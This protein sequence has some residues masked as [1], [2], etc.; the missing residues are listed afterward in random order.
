[1]HLTTASSTAPPSVW[2]EPHS[3]LDGMALIDHLFNRLD[4]LYP[5]R[6]RSAFA[7][8][9]AIAN[10][11]AAWADGFEVE[12]ITLAE[13][14]TGLDACRR[15]FAWPPSFAEFVTAC[16]PVLDAEAAYYEAVTQMQRREAG[17]D[18]WSA[19]AIF[20]AARKIG[21]DLLARPY[22]TLKGRWAVALV[23]AMDSV[24]NGKLP[25]EIPARLVPLPAPGKTTVPREVAVQRIAEMRDALTRKMTLAA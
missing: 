10:W 15:Q 22:A 2:L 24:R 17:E 13:V 23:E 6:W 18:T 19:P 3:R 9:Q 14:K 7:N 21:L 25:A 11:R 16:R 20:W 1:M 12:G 4:G 5:H 8:E